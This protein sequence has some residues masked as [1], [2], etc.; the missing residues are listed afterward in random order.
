LSLEIKE[1]YLLTGLSRPGETISLCGFKGVGD[2]TKNYISQHCIVGT[3]ESSGKIP[4]KNVRDLSLGTIL[5]TITR[6]VGS[7]APHLATNS[8]MQYQYA[9]DCMAPTVFNW[10]EGLLKSMKDQLTK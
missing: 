2:K 7:L 4:I 8:Q 3:R 5:F 10:C 9:V 1:I 6:F